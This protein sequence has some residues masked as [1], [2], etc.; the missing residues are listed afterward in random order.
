MVFGR[1]QRSGMHHGPQYS[2]LFLPIYVN[3][4]SCRHEHMEYLTIG[5]INTH[6]HV[7]A[8][9]A[10]PDSSKALEKAIQWIQICS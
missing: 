9:I 8:N 7:A 1:S 10:V 5:A 2:W 6:Q 3:D 4:E